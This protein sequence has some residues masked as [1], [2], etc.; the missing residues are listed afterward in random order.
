MSSTTDFLLKG[1]TEQH[2]QFLSQYAQEKLGST[3]RTKA[4]LA[5]IEQQMTIENSKQ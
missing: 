3:S 1:L 5:L 4:I 2:K